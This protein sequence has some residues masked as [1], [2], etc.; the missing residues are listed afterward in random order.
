MP[1]KKRSVEGC[2]G[3]IM[4]LPC[5]DED[6]LLDTLGYKGKRDNA[7]LIAAVIFRKAQSGDMNCIKEVIRMCGERTDEVADLVKIIDDIK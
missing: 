2:I 3:E 1:A 5:H 4:K 7:A 6:G